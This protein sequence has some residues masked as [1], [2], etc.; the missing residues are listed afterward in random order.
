MVNAFEILYIN[1]FHYGPSINVGIIIITIITT[2]KNWEAFPIINAIWQCKENAQHIFTVLWSKYG[3]NDYRNSMCHTIKLY[4]HSCWC[5]YGIWRYTLCHE[6]QN[7]QRPEIY[8]NLRNIH[9]LNEWIWIYG[10]LDGW[11]DRGCVLFK[12]KCTRNF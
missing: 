2:Y 1:I 8:L 11:I 9:M 6:Y 3:V 12:F 5:V 7:N 10:W 4:I